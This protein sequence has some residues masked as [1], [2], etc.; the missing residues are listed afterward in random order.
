VRRAAA[1]ERKGIGALDVEKLDTVF[2]THLHSDHTLVL[3][4][5]IYSP[6]VLDREAPLRLFGPPGVRKMAAHLQ[7]AFAEDID[8][9]LNGIQPSTPEGWKTNV[10][11]I[12]SGGRIFEEGALEVDAIPVPHGQW[13]YAYG[14][15]FTAH[16]KTIVVSGD[17]AKSEAILEAARGADILVHEVISEKGLNARPPEWQTYHHAYH[18]TTTELADIAREAKPKLLVLYHQLY[19]I[20]DAA[21]DAD[22]DL[23]A[24]I[25]AAGYDG[26]IVSA[27]DFDVFEP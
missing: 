27:K 15:K 4:D 23:V 12:K 26:E 8:L 24:E 19:E 14:Y 16:G 13:T 5:L 25:R 9:R 10:T 22:A 20:G 17:T 18:T 2:V 3:P 7:K 6:W 11:E 21:T 1:A